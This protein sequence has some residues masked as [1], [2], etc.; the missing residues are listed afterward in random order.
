VYV[1]FPAA[2][3]RDFFE[4]ARAIGIKGCSI[5][6]PHKVTALPYL[7]EISR[8]AQ[9]VGAVNTVSERDGKFYGENTD[10]HGVRAALASV[11]FSP[12]GRR[13][14]ILGAGGAARAA[15]AALRKAERVVVLS[16]SGKADSGWPEN[17]EFDSL[18]NIGAHSSDL[19]INATPVG[20]NP[21]SGAS[22]IEGRIPAEIVF[23]MVY[24]PAKTRLLSNAAAQG[25][26]IVSGTVMFLAQAQRQFEIWT[27]CPDASHLYTAE[28]LAS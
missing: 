5:T 2:D 18:A 1:R 19:L 28:Q 27:G 15:A 9:A 26:T 7:D 8:D 22:L 3:V 11:N 16:R 17:V 6:L 12:D 4:N 14:V 24:T 21:A 20:M 25:K 23:D 10:V 13:A